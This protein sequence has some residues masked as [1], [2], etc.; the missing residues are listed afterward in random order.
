LSPGASFRPVGLDQVPD[1]YR[2]MNEREALKVT[3]KPSVQQSRR[4]LW[5][6]A[7]DRRAR[8]QLTAICA[9]H[10]ARIDVKH[11]FRTAEAGGAMPEARALN[12]GLS[13]TSRSGGAAAHAPDI[14]CARISS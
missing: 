6:I 13:R 12:N 11:T 8:G 3:V 7:S 5:I 9:H 10:A 2:D 4:P 14:A 1:D